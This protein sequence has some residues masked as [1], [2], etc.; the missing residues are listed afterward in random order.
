MNNS[1]IVGTNAIY[2]GDAADSAGE[3]INFYRSSTTW[4]TLTAAG[5]ILYFN[6]NRATA[7]HT[8]TPV[9]SALA[10][11]GNNISITIGGQN[12]TLTPA[13]ATKAGDA[14][15]V[16]GYHANYFLPRMRM[17][18]PSNGTSYHGAIPYAIALKA[19]GTPVYTD[20]EFASGTNSVSVYNN[21]G[22]STVAISRIADNQGSA[23]SSGYI[24]QIVNNG[25]T[26]S[27]GRGGFY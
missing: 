3:G 18:N 19:A 15:T 5:G 13:Y 17:T 11:S 12:R 1:D 7:T 8:L 20:P 24:L 25:G 2:F 14:D 26:S 27:P 16:D 23:N 22:N 10:N 4:D 9:F 21:S 6:G